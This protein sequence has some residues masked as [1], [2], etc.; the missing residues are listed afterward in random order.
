MLIEIAA[1]TVNEAEALKVWS[2]VAKAVMITVL[3]TIVGMSN[4]PGTT[5]VCLAPAAEWVTLKPGVQSI[6]PQVALQSRPAFDG[7]PVTVA[8]RLKLPPD[9][10]DGGGSWVMVTPVMVEIMVTLEV[11][12]LL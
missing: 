8:A 10:N 6:P 12:A 7:S 4:G 11:E 1:V 3:P 2:A 9:G 5:N